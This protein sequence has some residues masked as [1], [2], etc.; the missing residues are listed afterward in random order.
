MGNE[1]HDSS[2]VGRRAFVASSAVAGVGAIAGCLDDLEQRL[3]GDGGFGDDG[4][5]TGD[6]TVTHWPDLMYNAPYHVALEN[7]YFEEEGIEIDF[8][9]SEG[10]GTT[11]RNVVDGGLPF[12]EVATPAAINAY[13][14]GTPI[15][16]VAGATR[17]VDEINWVAPTGSEIESIEDLEGGTMGFTSAGSVTETTAALVSSNVDEI[18]PESVEFQEMGGVGE[19]VTAVE[20]GAIDAAAN[21]DPIYSDQQEEEETW[22]VVF[23]AG[24]YVDRFQQTSIIVDPDVVEEYPD[25]V[26]TYLDARAQG[27]ESLREDPEAAAEVFSDGAEGFSTEVMRDAIENVDPDEYYTTG[28]FDVEGL[29]NVEEAMYATDL[30]DEDEDIPWDEIF[31]QS[32]LDED[33]HIDFEEI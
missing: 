18:D 32:F 1:S 8:V 3:T 2:E 12:G 17:T 20:D 23:W 10:G 13:L 24:D 7:G 15:V 31:D 16:V 14:A 4:T 9:G 11:V 30:L 6:A 26:E 33:D 27:I 5:F 22:Q 21:M 29:Q 25:A 19:G 28:E